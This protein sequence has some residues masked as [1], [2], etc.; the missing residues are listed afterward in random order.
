MNLVLEPLKGV[1]SDSIAKFLKENI[2]LDDTD[3]KTIFGDNMDKVLYHD[4]G[5]LKDLSSKMSDV[6]MP[7]YMKE[8]RYL[9]KIVSGVDD[10]TKSMKALQDRLEKDLGA[11]VPNPKNARETADKMNKI[12]EEFI[13]KAT[14]LTKTKIGLREV[15]PG[16]VSK[17][18]GTAEESLGSPVKQASPLEKASALVSPSK[19]KASP[20]A[21]M[22]KPIENA[23]L[24]TPSDIT[25]ALSDEILNIINQQ[26]T[27]RGGASA[28]SAQPYTD[29]QSAQPY[30]DQQ[31][32]QRDLQIGTSAQSAQRDLQSGGTKMPD[33]EPQIN[34][35]IEDHK[36][37]PKI[38]RRDYTE[39]D[40]NLSQLLNQ[41]IREKM[42]KYEEQANVLSDEILNSKSY[43]DMI[44]SVNELY[45]S[46]SEMQAETINQ[47]VHAIKESKISDKALQK[48]MDNTTK[49]IKSSKG[50]TRKKR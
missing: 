39:Y 21:A 23:V 18:E 28:Q 45:I 43:K 14:E 44:A 5:F 31:S 15:L 10:V 11:V 22:I 30:T 25:N 50:G 47:L 34:K 26:K 6:V 1:L 19:E 8:L 27:K 7:A 41:I 42:A 40:G 13:K 16:E 29:L 37:V 46:K 49:Q 48:I 36:N 9:K 2:K 3:I 4:E 20:T 35:Y 17:E 33:I 38:P 32:A 12:V 24:S